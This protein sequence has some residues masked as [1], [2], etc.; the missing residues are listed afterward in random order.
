MGQE[1]LRDIRDG[2]W[3]PRGGLGQ[4]GGPRVGFGLVEVHSKRYGTGRRTLKEDWDGLGGIRGG[5]ERVGD[6]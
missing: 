5:P 6:P 2:S 4:V 3:D 1:T